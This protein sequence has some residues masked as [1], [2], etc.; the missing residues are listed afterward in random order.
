MF[1]H[2]GIAGAVLE[3][4]AAIRKRGASMDDRAFRVYIDRMK[5]AV[6]GRAAAERLGLHGD[7]TRFFCPSCQRDG[8]RTPD[9]VVYDNGFKC[10][11]CGANGDVIDLFVLAGMSR[12]A[13]IKELEDMT[14]M[15]RKKGSAR[16]ST[17][18]P[19]VDPGATLKGKKPLTNLTNLTSLYSRFLDDVCRPLHGTPG[20]AYL[21]KRGI[22]ANTAA[23]SRVR[24]C[25]DLNGIWTLADKAAI[26][27]SGLTKLFPFQANSLPFLVFPYIRNG[28]PVFIKGRCLLSKDEADQRNIPRF[29]NTGGAIPCLWNHDAIKDA[30][31]ILICEGEID[32]LT[33]LEAGQA[34][35]GLPGAKNFK[36]EWIADFD[37]KD[38]VLVLDADKAGR[39]GAA[40]IARMFI[41]AGRKPPRQL[42][43]ADGQDLNEFYNKARGTHE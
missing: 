5:E 18:P 39:E 20:E 6:S 19:I 37:G 16:T 36:P 23:C 1:L 2:G 33:A 13:A 41:K 30:A 25:S 27:A 15:A 17:R 34:G 21:A 31:S 24:F 35:V 32:A 43:L 4:S 3:A 14:G 7:R 8:G 40:S 38:V 42:V 10:F 22:S 11:K 12:A 9:L 26:M 29:L 28:Q